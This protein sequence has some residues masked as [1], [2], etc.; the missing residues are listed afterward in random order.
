MSYC[1]F[2]SIWY[3][4]TQYFITKVTQRKKDLAY[5][6]SWCLIL[7]ILG[8]EYCTGADAGNGRMAS[9][10]ISNIRRQGLLLRMWILWCTRH[11]MWWRW[12]PL[13]Q[14]VLYWGLYRLHFWQWTIHL[15][16]KLLHKNLS[17]YSTLLVVRQ[18]RKINFTIIIIE[19]I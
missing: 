7:T 8:V 5:P 16:G 2:S 3:K 12:P 19:K 1:I 18:G 9:G 13:L 4:C 10:G 14:G 11:I 6:K 15:Q 17:F